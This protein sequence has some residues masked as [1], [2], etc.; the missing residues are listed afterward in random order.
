MHALCLVMKWP[1]GQVKAL[2]IDDQRLQGRTLLDVMTGGRLETNLGR[3]AFIGLASNES[4][5]FDPYCNA[6]GF[7]VIAGDVAFGKMRLGI[8]W[9]DTNWCGNPNGFLGIG[10]YRLPGLYWGGEQ[11]IYG[12][13][14][15]NW[16]THCKPRAVVPAW[17][18]LYILSEDTK[19]GKKK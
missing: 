10:Y 19:E 7:N 2:R 13:A 6:E 18:Y 17:S 5:N 14:A 16:D 3:E 12:G 4:K 11:E 1:N 15:C 8:L 9:D